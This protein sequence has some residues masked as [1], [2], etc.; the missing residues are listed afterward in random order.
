MALDI[1]Q[2]PA[3]SRI[4]GALTLAALLASLTLG[5]CAQTSLDASNMLA[6]NKAAPDPAEDEAAL[7]AQARGELEKATEWWGH[8]FAENPRDLKAA[9]SYARN[10]KAMGE[11]R[12]ALA[13]LQQASIFHGDSRELAG[14]Y[15]RLA[16]DLDQV[17]IATRLLAAADDPIHP[18][19]RIVSARGT[20]L[21][22]QGKYGEAIPFYERALTLAHNQ[23]SVLS[24]LALAHAMNGEP[25]KAEQMLR[26]AAAANPSELKIRQN[27]ALVLGL[28]GKYDEAKLVASRDLSA[29]KAAENTDYLRRIVKIE[30][31]KVSGAPEE[32]QVAWTDVAIK[33]A[34]TQVAAA[35]AKAPPAAPA[36]RV[37]QTSVILPERKPAVAEA[38]K[39]PPEAP[40]SDVAEPQKV[41]PATQ[42][43]QAQKAKEAVKVADTRE[44]TPRLKAT[45]SPAQIGAFVTKV[46][47]APTAKPAA[48]APKVADKAASA[49]AKAAQQPQSDIK[50]DIKVAW[51]TSEPVPAEAPTPTEGREPQQ[52]SAGT[53][54]T[55]VALSQPAKAKRKR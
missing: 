11:K 9:L 52:E 27:L 42:I 1:Q 6:S 24:N 37:A 45:Q 18:D 28:Q 12:R 8:Q 5:A 50:S 31:K 46:V 43:A 4:R 15:G 55:K 13:V 49:P 21:A 25:A 26:Q 23:P 47:R 22:K 34:P 17:G 7:Q 16:L 29:E 14:E 39:T 19:W 35:V 41:K 20:V 51:E 32:P 53:W 54:A 3:G 33:L 40:K 10:L 30:P 38:R 2:Q 48:A 36:T 44:P